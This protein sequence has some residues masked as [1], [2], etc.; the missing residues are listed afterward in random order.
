MSANA[1]GDPQL[2]WLDGELRK[3]K[4]IA[5]ELREQLDK[6][7][8]EMADQQQRLSSLEDRLAKLQ[9]QLARIPAVEEGL[10]HTRDELVLKMAELR[11]EVQ[12]RDAEFLRNRQ[13]E[14]ERDVLS[15]QG[16]EAELKRIGPL[17]QA[18]A[19]RQAEDHRLNEVQQ[20]TQQDVTA[21]AERV[22]RTEETLRQL[23]DRVEQVFVK[24]GQAEIAA[25]DLNKAR[26]G[27]AAR[28]LV[29]EDALAKSG[30]RV[31]ALEGV[32]QEITRREEELLETQRRSDVER[33]QTLTEWGRRLEEVTHQLDV[34]R[35]QLRYFAD[36]HDKS[37]RVLRD[38]QELAQQLSQQQDQLRQVQ[39][40]AEEQLRRELREWRSEEDRR[41]AT[42]TLAQSKSIEEQSK[43][44]QA[45]DAHLQDLDAKR[46]QD[47]QEL[48]AVRD[49]LAEARVAVEAQLRTVREALLRHLALEREAMER[50]LTEMSAMLKPE[51]D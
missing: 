30:Q 31:A 11:Q 7:T 43:R 10:Q 26:Q 14:R 32:R 49:A 2:S 19:T 4:A 9:A 18:L 41:W 50:A 36:Q 12:K 47:V 46:V 27:D 24:L 34:W 8:V 48:A 44:D 29:I 20:R 37:R 16:I 6:R 42:A 23:A 38:M 5:T 13:A 3:Q 28:M 22:H 25:L 17:E 40:I 45:R 21:A 51:E 15:I 39:R 35:D 1:Q 33:S